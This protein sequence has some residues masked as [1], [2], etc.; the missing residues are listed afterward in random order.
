LRK[1]LCIYQWRDELADAA[2]PPP[3]GCQIQQQT[4]DNG[5]DAKL[6]CNSVVLAVKILSGL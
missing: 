1:L 2:S 4:D 5:D 6:I 3:P